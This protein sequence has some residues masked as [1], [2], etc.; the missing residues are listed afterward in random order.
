M[1][2]SN[3]ARIAEASASLAAKE[4][5][6]AAVWTRLKRDILRQPRLMRRYCG[7]L[8]ACQ[9]LQDEISSLSTNPGANSFL[10][11]CL[12]YENT[13]GADSRGIG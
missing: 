6:T 8:K 11:P 9:R 4:R 7:H 2:Q 3:A 5:D 13:N 12:N 1:E 10:P